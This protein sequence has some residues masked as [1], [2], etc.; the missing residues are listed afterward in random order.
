MPWAQAMLSFLKG[1]GSEDY[2]STMG[3]LAFLKLTICVVVVVVVVND[4]GQQQS[5]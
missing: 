2:E 3:L 1:G 5:R 4:D